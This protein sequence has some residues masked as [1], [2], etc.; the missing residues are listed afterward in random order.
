VPEALGLSYKNSRELNQIIDGDLPEGRPTFTRQ[1]IVVGGEAFDVYFRPI[2]QC[3]KAL[4]GDPEFAEELVFMPERHYSDADKTIRFYDD[5][6]TA[7]WWWQ[8]QVRY[9]FPVTVLSSSH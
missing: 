8:T 6:H 4:Y 9:I 5:M 7:E 3:L 2:V 1:E